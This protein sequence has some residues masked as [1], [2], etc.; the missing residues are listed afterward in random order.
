[1]RFHFTNVMEKLIAESFA[2]ACAF[3][4]ASDID[5][6]DRGWRDFFRMGNLCDSRQSRIGYRDDPDIRI[7]RAERI[8]FGWRLV[9]AR[10]R[11]EKRRFP[12]VRKTDNSS[13]KHVSS[14]AAVSGARKFQ[15]WR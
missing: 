15:R 1:N 5:E 4:Q 8:I 12:H 10:D 13:A 3:D 9:S 6:L 14:V 11:V 2:L 7:D